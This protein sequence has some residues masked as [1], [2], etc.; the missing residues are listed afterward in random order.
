MNALGECLNVN[1]NDVRTMITLHSYRMEGLMPSI[2]LLPSNAL[3]PTIEQRYTIA[4]YCSPI[5][6]CYT[7]TLYCSA[8]EQRY[9][10]ALYCSAIEQNGEGR[11]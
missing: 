5:E 6:Q 4:Q 7:I 10:I 8:I 11:L 1:M 3:L 9:T 2:A